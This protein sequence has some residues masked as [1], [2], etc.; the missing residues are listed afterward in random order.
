MVE[1]GIVYMLIIFPI[2]AIALGLFLAALIDQ[3]YKDLH[4]WVVEHYI[5]HAHISARKHHM[6]S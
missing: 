1:P 3:L 5:T 4:N 6:G 2:P